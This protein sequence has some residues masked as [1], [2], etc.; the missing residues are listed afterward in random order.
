M[1][2]GRLEAVMGVLTTTNGSDS[3]ATAS[4]ETVESRASRFPRKGGNS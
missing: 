2:V 3:S 4:L 1:D